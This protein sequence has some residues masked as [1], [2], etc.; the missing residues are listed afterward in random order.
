[1][2]TQPVFL[3]Y[4][5]GM[6]YNLVP[7]EDEEEHLLAEY[8]D[9]KK[10]KHCH[11]SNEM[12]TSSWKQKHKMKYLGVASGLPDHLVIV[13]RKD[14]VTVP[15]YIEMKKAKGGTISDS[16]FEWIETLLVAKQYATVC[17]GGDEAIEFVT[18]VEEN[19]EKV[20]QEFVE[21][22]EKKREKRL[23]TIEKR[24]K[25]KKDNPF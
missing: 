8:C 22:F 19:N 6:G 7:S 2:F 23:K 11:F 12:W 21:K 13:K 18:A 9:L 24:E 15:A 25:D 16:Q 3:C 4:T 10:W 20:I 14:G 17:A 1:M 5:G